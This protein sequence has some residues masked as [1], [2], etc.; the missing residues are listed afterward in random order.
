M[1]VYELQRS[2]FINKNKSQQ[3]SFVISGRE[4]MGMEKKK[5]LANI[6]NCLSLTFLWFLID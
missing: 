6:V 4:T 5:T 3:Q 2:P 1:I